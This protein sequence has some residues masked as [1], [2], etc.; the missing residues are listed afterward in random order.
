MPTMTNPL[1][2]GFVTA[3]ITNQKTTHEVVQNTSSLREPLMM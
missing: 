2:F 3:Y 1:H